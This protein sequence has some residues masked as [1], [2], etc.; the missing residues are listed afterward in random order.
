MMK[1][2][3][4]IILIIGCIIF[5]NSVNITCAFKDT[6]NTNVEM[7]VTAKLS[8]PIQTSYWFLQRFFYDKQIGIVRKISSFTN[9][10]YKFY[11]NECNHK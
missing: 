1:N 8:P 5:F 10:F 7:M 6:T 11:K 2:K 9:V 4:Q 3:V